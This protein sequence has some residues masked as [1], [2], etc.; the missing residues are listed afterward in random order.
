MNESGAADTIREGFKKGQGLVDDLA[1]KVKSADI[2]GKA[3]AGLEKGKG[4]V[5]TLVSK[6][7]ALFNKETVVNTVETV[8][9][10]AV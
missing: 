7:K 8:V 3:Q 2:K 5:E 6:A 1:D 4:F 9:D 10:S